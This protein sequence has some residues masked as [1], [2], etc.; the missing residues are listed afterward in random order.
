[1]SKDKDLTQR[2]K[3]CKGEFLSDKQMRTDK[4]TERNVGGKGVF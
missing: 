1:M 2:S 4:I 3:G